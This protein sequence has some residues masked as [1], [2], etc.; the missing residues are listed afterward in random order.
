[1]FVVDRAEFIA[2]H[3]GILL[4]RDAEGNVICPDEIACEKA[5]KLLNDGTSIYLTMGG[6]IFSV[7]VLNSEG[8]YEEILH[9]DWEQDLIPK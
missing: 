5:L 4:D 1:M 2:Y 7:M 6:E 9:K 3:N 8:N